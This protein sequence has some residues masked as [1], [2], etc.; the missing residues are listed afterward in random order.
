MGA[1]VPQP[2][3]HSP[4]GC[5]SLLSLQAWL[6]CGET[7]SLCCGNGR[8]TTTPLPTLPKAWEEMFRT[9]AFRK[10]SRQY[11]NLFAF[12]AMG[13]SGDK[14]FMHQPV[15][16]SVKIHG[17]TYLRVLLAK[18]QGPVQWYVHDHDQRRGEANTLSL[19]QQLVD[20]IQQALTSINL[21][22]QSLRQQGQEPAEHVSLEVEWKEE[23][24]EI[25][26]INH[27]AN[28]DVTGGP[29]TV[30]FWKRRELAPT[31][32]SHSKT[33]P[34]KNPFWLGKWNGFL[35]TRAGIYFTRK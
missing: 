19:H 30:V 7:E 28:S 23:S 12:T 22:A 27:R 32:V 31:F 20:A 4:W 5:P 2:P 33:A 18:M 16:S 35:A 10:H 14:D 8:I 11:N 34:Q 29:R 25:S 1:R 9:P 15:P 24:R 21:Y 6:L 17:R 26:A 13:V 3:C